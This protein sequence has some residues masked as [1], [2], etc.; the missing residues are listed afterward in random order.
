MR[1]WV[2]YAATAVLGLTGSGCE[3][4]EGPA[5]A[6]WVVVIG[7]DATVPQFGDRLLIEILDR[8]GEPACDA[9]R[10]QLTAGSAADWPVSFGVLP[11]ESGDPLWI[12]ATLYRT[13]H[14][15]TDGLPRGDS[16]IEALGQLPQTDS[17]LR[18]GL[19]LHMD[20]FGVPADTAAATSCDPATGLP[21]PAVVL[22]EIGSDDDLLKP[23]SWPAGQPVDCSGAVPDG[24]VCVPGGVFLLGGLRSFSGNTEPEHLV[25][26]SPYALDTDELT[27]ATL[28]QLVLDGAINS[29]PTSQ[30]P[31]PKEVNG[32]CTYDGDNDALPVN[33]INRDLARAACVAQGKRLPTEA[34]WEFAAGNRTRETSYPWGED[35]DTCAHAVVGRGRSILEL[36][37]TD[38]TDGEF[39]A[40]R[41][42]GSE[43]LLPWGPVAGDAGDDLTDQGLRHLA[44]NLSEWVA[45]AVA[46]YQDPCWNL[47][48]NLLIDPVCTVSTTA[49]SN[50]ATT[51]GGRWLMLPF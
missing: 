44:G 29:L 32:A 4:D 41:G 15:G 10:R 51:R 3:P 24:M 12:R 50:V 8:T 11:S 5:R 7:T 25:K 22:T 45:D 18:V 26:L 31:D 37:S 42:A 20:C 6:Q 34:E 17:V 30:H 39:D 49:S 38:A 43:E 23:D 28:R 16:H 36:N 21:A 46:T 40:C 48:G 35:D 19:E 9:C 13:D 2:A 1:A 47:A 33:C 14:L 27:V